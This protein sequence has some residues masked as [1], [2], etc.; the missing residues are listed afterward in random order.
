MR[1]DGW[2]IKIFKVPVWQPILQKILSD[3]ISDQKE[4]MLM[5]N[6]YPPMRMVSSY[7][8]VH[9]NYPEIWLILGNIYNYFNYS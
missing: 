7:S 1:L 5:L 2:K 6:P 9:H 4:W 3:F 8:K